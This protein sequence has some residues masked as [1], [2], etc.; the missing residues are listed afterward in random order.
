MLYFPI[1]KYVQCLKPFPGR[2]NHVCVK[3][4]KVVNTFKIFV[5]CGKRMLES[6]LLIVIKLH[7]GV[8]S[9]KISQINYH[10]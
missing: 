5:K 3:Q 6:K 9:W 7:G 10:K 8:Q 1:L 4:G 2:S